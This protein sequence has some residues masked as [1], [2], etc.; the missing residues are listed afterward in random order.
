MDGFEYI[1]FDD[2]L[3]VYGIPREEIDMINPSFIGDSDNSGI[4]LYVGDTNEN[5]LADFYDSYLG[6]DVILKPSQGA[7]FG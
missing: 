4:W 6:I 3:N 1:T 7:A 5:G 2:L